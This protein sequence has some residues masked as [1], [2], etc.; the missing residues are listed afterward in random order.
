M[1]YLDRLRMSRGTGACKAAFSEICRR[2]KNRAAALINERDLTF[3]SLFVLSAEIATFRLYAYLN[4]RPVTALGIIDQV[5][6]RPDL[7]YDA[8][9][10][11]E[12]SDAVYPVL[13]WIIETGNAQDVISGGYEQVLDITVSVLTNLYGDKSVLPHA[14]DMIFRRNREGR[15]MH[16]LVWA[17]FGL[18]DP[19][20]LRLIAERIR[21]SDGQ[22]AALACDLL[23]IEQS[24]DNQAQYEAYLRWLGENEPFLYFTGESFQF[25]ARPVFCGVDLERKFLQ[26]SAPPHAMEPVEPSSGGEPAS[27][28]SFRSLNLAEKTLLS[29]YSHAMHSRDAAAWERWIRLP[30]K[31]QIRAA[32][33][34]WE[35]RT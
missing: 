27:L 2:D 18:C 19:G 35:D 11:S 33:D 5:L 6:E 30:V 32:I 15:F 28:E 21:S 4:A 8:N 31:E 12:R 26:R 29:D 10:L 1:G 9:Y 17:A 3:P 25:A 7:G 13:K 22:D 20:V 24:G 23:N 14:V 34:G 16:D